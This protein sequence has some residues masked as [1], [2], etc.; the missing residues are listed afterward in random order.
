MKSFLSALASVVFA[1]GILWVPAVPA[2]LDDI[3]DPFDIPSPP[4]P[5]EGIGVP[6]I[7]DVTEVPGDT[8][9]N[10][11]VAILLS[12]HSMRDLSD[13]VYVGSEF[14]LACHPGHAGWKDTRH[15]QALRRPMAQFSLVAGK[16]VVADYDRN[17]VDDFIQGLDFNEIN[18][19]FDPYKPNAPVLSFDGGVYY[20]TIGEL[21]MPVI[22]TQGGTGE[23][24]QRYLLRVPVSGTADGLT[25]EN[26]VS[27]V[28]FNERTFGYVAYHPEQWWDQASGLPLYGAGTSVE[29]LADLGRSYSKKCIGCHTTGIKAL[30]QDGNGEWRYTPYPA[31]LF[32]PDDPSYYDYDHDGQFDI[33]NV[34]CEACHGP[35][36]KHILGA[37][38]PSMIV[39]PDDLDTEA[40]N[41]V[42]GQCHSRVKSVPNGTHDWPY[43]DDTGTSFIPGQGDAL[44]DFFTDASGRWA[45]GINS[46]QH[47]QQWLDFVDSPKPGFQFHPVK[48]VECH[49]SHGD[50]NNPRLIRDVLVED[51]LDIA[52]QT[53]DNTLCLA[54]HAGFG[55]FSD[56]NKET[57]ADIDEEENLDLV[58]KVVSAHSKH[59]Y[60]PERRMGLARCVDCHMPTIAKS[61]INYDIR[62]HVFEAIPPEKTSMYQDQGGMPNS[63]A[64]SCHSLKVNSFGLRLD[65]DI[66]D[67]DQGFDRLTAIELEKYFG[68]GGIWWDTEDEDS[69]T[70]EH[71]KNAS[72]PG[73]Y[74]LPPD[75]DLDD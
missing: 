32:E 74:Q 9:A 14:C 33:V 6:P 49:D 13:G 23:W 12:S 45:D 38:D 46:R 65:P 48:C 56:L 44:A 64:V 17:G 37:G 73:E 40:A 30:G 70:S 7:N 58:A 41:E 69:A 51:G 43:L 2:Q 10:S 63:C 66:S 62:S 8:L 61:A 55:P 53:G 24:K 59:P 19:V 52:T 72:P 25:G 36:S 21:Q 15:A 50:T 22:S 39:N 31:V 16:G 3:D 29:T 5:P 71:L 57:I 26:Y 27:P 20:I 47:H 28:Q 67:W 35:G 4:Q 54:C 68:P 18:S 11:H 1:L 42:C 75:I 34:G 60:A